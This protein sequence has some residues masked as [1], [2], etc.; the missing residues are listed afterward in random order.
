MTHPLFL[1]FQERRSARRPTE[2]APARYP[3]GFEIRRKKG[4]TYKQRVICN[5]PIKKKSI[6][7]CCGLQ[8]RRA[9]QK[10]NFTD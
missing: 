2:F 7:L 9:P 4:S 1:V 3:G 10:N 5:P 8:I 6:F